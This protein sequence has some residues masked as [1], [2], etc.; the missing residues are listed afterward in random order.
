MDIVKEIIGK[1]GGVNGTSEKTGFAQQTVSAWI[2]REPPEI[3]PWRRAFIA[4]C[5]K[6]SR[7]ALA[8]EEKEYLASLVRRPK[9][10]PSQQEAA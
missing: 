7:I 6:D 8:A 10:R 2:C 9:A 3:P 5:A 1:L 4:K